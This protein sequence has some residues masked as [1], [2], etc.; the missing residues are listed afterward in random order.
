MHTLGD[1]TMTPPLK[2][3][4]ARSFGFAEARHLLNRAG[5]GGTPAQVEALRAMGL[6]A[7]VDYLVDYEARPEP[8]DAASFDPDIMR[9][10]TAEE[11]AFAREARRNRDEN[12]LAQIQRT[13]MESERLDRL[14]LAEMRKWWLKRLIETG[15]PL[16]EKMTL[17]WHGHFATG[18]RTIENS[19]HCLAQNRLFRRLATGN[20]AALVAGVVRDPAMIRYLDNDD[21]RQARPNENLARELMELFTLGEGNGY[22]ESDIKEA[23]R[24]LTGYTFRDDEF[25][26]DRRQHDGRIKTILGQ[27]GSFDGD[28]LVRILMQRRETGEFLCLKLH[29]FLVNDAPGE[30]DRE[31]REAV[32]AMARELRES[33]YELKPVLKALFRSAWFHDP[34]NRGSVIKSPIQLAVQAIRS[35]R[36]PSRELSALA[37][38][39]DLMGQS[40]FQPPN[41][42]GWDGGRSWINTSTLYVRQNL[43]VY[44]ITGRRPN[45]YDWQLS[46]ARF[47]ATHLVEEPLRAAGDLP[48]EPRELAEWLLR[49]SLA[50]P[51]SPERIDAVAAILGPGRPSNDR[52]LAALCLITALP[53]YQ[54]C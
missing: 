19:W 9:P 15:R 53:E 47:D 33:R 52:L 45:A 36:T 28:D 51:P 37:S 29:R 38:A 13:R 39:T 16:E 35:F 48:P 49:F 25:L 26:F 11:Q 3:L 40:L 20:Y 4:P 5:F 46:D 10:A 23:A 41:V 54:L 27:R 6:H 18:Y 24:A 2:A 22:T 42:K 8:E 34:A 30:P 1:D 21:N 43:L 44:L 31:T 7:A 32:V 50:V 14:Q 12:A 17:F